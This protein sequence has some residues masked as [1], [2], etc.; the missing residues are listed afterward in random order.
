MSA[1]C[2]NALLVVSQSLPLEVPQFVFRVWSSPFSVLV[3]SL[4]ML[5][6]DPGEE[7]GRQV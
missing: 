2:R 7:E 4:H 6:V 3:C 5:P 1:L